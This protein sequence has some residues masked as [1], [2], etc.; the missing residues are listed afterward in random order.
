[1]KEFFDKVYSSFSLE[2][3]TEITKAFK[4]NTFF[5]L[6]NKIR[7]SFD[8]FAQEGFNHHSNQQIACRKGCSFCC[9]IK[10]TVKA[11]EVFSIIEYLKTHCSKT[12]LEQILIEAKRNSDHIS[13]ISAEEQ[14]L[15]NIKCPLLIDGICTVYPVR[16]FACRS[17]HSTNLNN[18]KDMYEHPTLDEPS[19]EIKG[20]K[21][22]LVAAV[23]GISEA[24]NKCGYDTRTY[25]LTHTLVEGLE[26]SK[27]FKRWKNKKSAFSSMSLAKTFE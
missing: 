18:C 7:E 3:Q 10:V 4:A 11:H 21:I 6:F 25:D 14:L 13:K 8:K 19:A 22:G 27:I 17:Y 12:E 20:I 5:I 24:F 1:M 16:P 9:Y 26:N 15:T 23:H 2:V